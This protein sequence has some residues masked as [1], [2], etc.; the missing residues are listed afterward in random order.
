M[1]PQSLY[2]VRPG[3]YAVDVR[4]LGI[5]QFLSTY[6][7][8]GRE[9]AVI[10]PGPACSIPN[11]IGALEALGVRPS[12]LRYV[13]ATHIH[14][15]HAGG[16]GLLLEWAEGAKLLVHERG[17]KH[18]VEPGRLWESTKAVLGEIALAY[19]EIKPVE[20]ERIAGL[21]EGDEIN[22]GSGLRLYV[23]ETP[24]HA[25][26]HLSFF[27]SGG[28]I[29]FT[30][31]SAGVYIRSL[32]AVVP[33]TP[34]PFRLDLALASL[35]K[36][37]ELMPEVICYAHFGHAEEATKMLEGHKEQLRLW[38]EVVK[39][40]LNEPLNAILELLMSR[41][42]NLARLGHLVKEDTVMHAVLTR[43]LMGMKGF[44]ER[45]SP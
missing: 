36:Q 26:H 23:L 33:T 29:L 32:G 24:G 14:I 18:M 6:V 43:S 13:L 1:K 10:D 31:D 45:K 3:L 44:L 30:G 21:R 19:G 16:A 7:L 5:E 15:D 42:P 38:A 41:D 17:V 25:S 39:E 28:R 2:Q 34:P 22:L 20:E 40:H 8:L 9:V 35:D 4:P 37:V 12:S 11:L 27:E